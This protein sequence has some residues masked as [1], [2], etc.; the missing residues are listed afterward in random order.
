MVSRQHQKPLRRLYTMGVAI[1][2][3]FEHFALKAALKPREVHWDTQFFPELT[4]VIT[5]EGP[6]HQRT[7]FLTINIM[8]PELHL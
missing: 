5:H 2:I 7:A 1:G 6:I 4:T 8:V 3:V